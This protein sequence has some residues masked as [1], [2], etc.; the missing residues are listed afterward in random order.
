MSR[1]RVLLVDDHPMIRQGLSQIFN[2]EADLEVVG[3][4]GDSQSALAAADELR[5]DIFICDINLPGMNG[6][7]LVRALRRRFPQRPIVVLTV[8]HDDAQ[9]LAAVRAGADAF[10]NKDSGP[11]EVI[12]IVRRVAAGEAVI[13]EQVQA[14]PE[15][16]NRLVAQWQTPASTEANQLSFSPLTARELEIL[17]CI[18]RGMSNKEM[19]AQL[20]ISDQTVKNHVTALLRKLGVSDRTQAIVHAIRQ[21]WVTIGNPPPS[22]P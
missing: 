17:D 3:A 10:V 21:G 6:L 19:A 12:G 15:L 7:E 14:R 16:V 20:S 5:P 22:R 2:Q 9:L 1:L 4:V 11:R 8:H 18:A 13:R